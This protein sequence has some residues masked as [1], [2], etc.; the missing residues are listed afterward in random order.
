MRILLSAFACNPNVGSEPGVGWNWAVEIARLGHEVLVLTQNINQSAIEAAQAAG[1]L[2][3]RLR[4]AYLGPA[5]LARLQARGL[6]LQICHLVW[7][8]VAWRHARRLL[9]T[10][11]F[12]LTHHI[13]YAGIRQASFLGRLPVPFV[14]GPV[15]GGERAPYALRRGL[16]GRGWLHELIRDGLNVLSRIDPMTQQALTAAKLIFVS[17][18][19][20]ARLV[21]A[22]HQAKIRVQLQIGI[23]PPAEPADRAAYEVRPDGPLRLLFAGRCLAWKGMHL[24]LEALAELLG[25]GCWARLTI[26]GSGSAEGLWRARAQAL[27]LD[28][29]VDWMARVEHA[30]MADL[31]RAHDVLLFPSLHDSG[32]QVVLEALAYG[33]PVVCLDLGGP[34]RIV[35]PRCGR[36]IATAG[37]TRAQVV[38]DL[39]DALHALATSAPL[40]QQLGA[41]AIARARE[42]AWGRLVSGVYA[43]IGQALRADPAAGLQT[44]RA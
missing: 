39:T 26:L 28:E 2:P 21:P 34:G 16:G 20:T 9:A 18:P 7:Q 35:N 44:Q 25:R 17:N 11:H 31:Y 12:D 5:W 8:V 13:T 29:A 24:G 1:A 14:L 38:H 23:H 6:P 30:R 19:D 32:G 37:R 22:R 4:F 10:Q 41:G 36:V 33:R 42:F 40:R 43:E 27:G 15:G 3:A